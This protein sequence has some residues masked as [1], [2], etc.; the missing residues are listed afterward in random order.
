MSLVCT[1]SARTYS[2][3]WFTALVLVS[4]I[5]NV[6]EIVNIKTKYL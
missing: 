5:Y 4:Q 2:T 1:P 3:E 6:I